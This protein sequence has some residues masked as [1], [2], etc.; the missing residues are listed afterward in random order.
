MHFQFFFSCTSFHL[1]RD[2]LRKSGAPCC[3]ETSSSSFLFAQL[4]TACDFRLMSKD[5]EI[6]FVQVK[7]GLTPGWGGGARLVKLLGKQ[8]ALQLLGKGEK[9]D[10]SYGHQL[11]LVDGELQPGQV[12]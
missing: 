12:G 7:M 4:T 3:L 11:G 9:V 6:R 1:S 8:K 5:A 2:S 10:L